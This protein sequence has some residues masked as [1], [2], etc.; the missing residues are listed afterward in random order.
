MA[1]RA[2]LAGWVRQKHTQS[3]IDLAKPSCEMTCMGEND[4]GVMM[5]STDLSLGIPTQNSATIN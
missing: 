2:K 1:N 5:M 4:D 3:G